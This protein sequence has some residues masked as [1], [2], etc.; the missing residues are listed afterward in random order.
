MA[1]NIL[2]EDT[3]TVK[4]IEFTCTTCSSPK[5]RSRDFTWRGSIDLRPL[6]V[7]GLVQIWCAE[8]EY[9]GESDGVFGALNEIEEEDEDEGDLINIATVRN[10]ANLEAAV[11]SLLVDAAESYRKRAEAMS[12]ALSS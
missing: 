7:E 5:G 12:R 10:A 4:G 1:R 3:I 9:N 6:G 11:Q 8:N 2:S